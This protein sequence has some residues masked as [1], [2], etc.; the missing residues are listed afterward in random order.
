LLQT[1][2]LACTMRH[3]TILFFFAFI[4]TT[5]SAQVFQTHHESFVNENHYSVAYPDNWNGDYFVI[6]TRNAESGIGYSKKTM[7]IKRIDITGGI[8][9]ESLV[10]TPDYEQ[11]LFALHVDNSSWDNGDVTVVGFRSLGNTQ[12]AVIFGVRG[13]GTVTEAKVLN[14]PGSSTIFLHAIS[15]YPSGPHPITNA[16]NDGA[17][18]VAV[19][20]QH[21]DNSANKKGL[22]VRYTSIGAIAWIRNFNTLIGDNST[23][24]F[25]AINHVVEVPSVGFFLSGSGNYFSDDDGIYKQGALAMMLDFNGELKWSRIYS[26]SNYAHSTVAA[27]ATYTADGELYQIANGQ[28]DS[29]F[30]ENGFSVHRINPINGEFIGQGNNFNMN[31]KGLKAMTLRNHKNDPT[32]LMVSGFLETATCESD[33][34]GELISENN[35][36]PFLMQL[37]Q[38]LDANTISLIDWH[39]IYNV[40]SALYGTSASFLDVFSNI[41]Q[42]HIY[43]PEMMLPLSSDAAGYLIAGLHKNP[44]G[45]GDYDLELILTDNNGLTQ[46]PTFQGDILTQPAEPIIVVDTVCSEITGMLLDPML[47]E[48]LPFQCNPIPCA[49]CP[50]PWV[51]PT[52]E[53]EYLNLSVGLISG[54]PS[55]LCFEVDYGDGS[56]VETFTGEQL[57]LIHTWEEGYTGGEV[58]VTSWCCDDPCTTDIQCFTIT[59]PD[60]CHCSPCNPFLKACQIIDEP[61]E[62]IGEETN[63]MIDVLTKIMECSYGCAEGPYEVELS[64]GNLFFNSLAFNCLENVRV[65]WYVDGQFIEATDCNMYEPITVTVSNDITIDITAVLTNCDDDVCEDVLSTS[66]YVGRCILPPNPIIHINEFQNNTDCTQPKCKMGFCTGQTTCS[67]YYTMESSWYVDGIQSGDGAGCI[68][69]CLNWGF[70]K[71]ELRYTCTTTGETSSAIEYIYCGPPYELGP[72]LI[73]IASGWLPQYFPMSAEIDTDCNLKIDFGNMDAEVTGTFSPF[74]SIGESTFEG[75][76]DEIDPSEKFFSWRI[77]AI[78]E[79][80]NENIIVEHNSYSDADLTWFS[81]DLITVK[82]T[83]DQLISLKFELTGPDWLVSQTNPGTLSYEIP[84]SDCPPAVICASDIDGDSYVNVNDLLALLGDFGTACE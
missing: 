48:I 17:G 77:T 15:T 37:N 69:T 16:D 82:D 27:S 75:L 58:C 53:C 36:P 83:F 38:V 6:G 8:I 49:E 23:T 47:L 14:S 39:H 65:D 25:D 50:I 46:C 61:I 26:H 18:W 4:S 19:G 7:I 44:T 79:N 32:V 40:P 5:S 54:N 63:T 57:G 62:L 41:N 2:Y 70:H 51:D 42:P 11:N 84:V 33:I 13:D 72:D 81:N 56:L 31:N 80:G 3:L 35:H 43:H 66:L 68:S 12:R 52:A 78:E 55:N 20:S 59:L 71:I 60:D 30:N 34:A 73:D 9:W 64:L 24:D 67:N 1:K 28:G 10:Y 29:S 21:P 22:I 76:L 74:Q 45:T